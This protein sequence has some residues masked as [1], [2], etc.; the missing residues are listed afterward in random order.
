MNKVRLALAQ[1]NATVGDIEG[2][3]NKIIEYINKA[4]END[5]DI[6]IFPELSITGYPPEDLLFKSH[7]VRKN[8]EAIEE[9]ARH[10]PKSLVVVVGFVDEEGDIFNAAAVIN[11][12]KVQAKYRKNYLPNYGVFDEM[13]YF[14]KGTK[15]LVVLLEDVRVGI[16]ICEDIW[17]PGGPARLESLLGDA[18]L[19]VN[20]SASP[21]YVEK[22]AWRERMLSVRANDNI[23]TVA[24]VNCVGGQDELIFDGASLVVNEKGEII[25]RAKQFEEDLLIVDVDLI[26]IDKTCVKDP[27]RRQDKQIMDE[28]RKNLEIVKLPFE[29]KPKR[30]KITNRVEKTLPK[31]AEVYNALVLATRDYIRKNGMKKAVIGLSGGMDS[32][33]VACIAVDALGAE[34]VVGVSMPGPFSSEHSKEDAKI[35][36]ENLGIKF[37]TIPIMEAYNSFLNM[38]KPVFEDRPFDITE[39]NLQARIR[40]VILMAL[41]NKFG[42]IV[43]TTGNKSEISTGYSTL[44]G[45][46]AGGYAV[47]KDVYKTFVYELAEYVNQKYGREIIPRRVFEKA[48]SAELRENQ[49]DQDKLPPYEILDEILKL[50]VEEDYSVSDIVERGFDE[51]TVKKVAW[52]VD[53]NEYKRRQMPPGPKITHRAFGKD[54]RLPITNAFKEWLEKK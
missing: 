19:I 23:A 43:L 48:P 52:M 30:T 8:K 26:D 32:T 46:T 21:Y 3:K 42:W 5:V 40:G 35:L 16:T 11:D 54:R 6:V 36:A 47:I 7:F 27:R 1:I 12:G 53:I 37:L 14:Q 17:Y 15:A 9:I 44:Y 18:Q 25:G 39:E 28:E 24:Y 10:V 50:Y 51:E 49:T 38:F 31:V 13:R 2:N 34:N 45:D 33:L 4:L 41:S 20:L 29:S 22:I